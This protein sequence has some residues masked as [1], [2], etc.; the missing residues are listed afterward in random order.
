MFLAETFNMLLNCF[1]MERG[2]KGSVLILAILVLGIMVFLASYFI[3]FGL[4][5]SG[6]ARNQ[7]FASQTYYLAESGVAE[8]IFKLKNDPAWKNAFETLPTPS[9]PNCSLWSIS[10]FQRAGG[11][12]QNGGYNITVNNLGCAK[13]EIVSLAYLDTGG[14][15]KAQRVVKVKV[16]KA[17]GNPISDYGVFTGGASE[18]LDI[19]ATNP[20]H[21]H[22]GSLF[23]NNI[24]KVRDGSL[25][26]VDGKA[27][28]NGNILFSSGGQIQG[29]SCG[30][31][32]CQAGCATSTECPPA[33]ITS[34]PLDIISTNST[35]YRSQAQNDDCS[36][37]RNDGKTNCIFATDEFERMLWMYYPQFS[38]PTNVVVYVDGDVNIRAGQELTVNGVLA[39]GRDINL[40]SSLCWSR[41][42]Y[43][44]LRCGF[45]RVTVL[46]PGAPE[47]NLPSG[48]LAYRKINTSSW[49]GFGFS[50]LNVNGL[51]YS[52]DETKLSSIAA[53][54]VIHGGVIARKFTLSSLWNGTDIYLDSDVIVDT[55][56]NPQYSSIITIDHWEE[57]Y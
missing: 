57:E 4:T 36:S 29:V 30:S 25:V 47:D 13:A 19:S 34:P 52:G 45:A 1:K 20:M 21:V 17:M 18:N 55:L 43:P 24:L 54:I 35:S 11:I 14:S 42:E 49:L 3:S 41:G 5:G 7:K 46:R 16:L 37:V 32:L 6:M 51:I 2:R 8:A 56:G 50:A 15:K 31:N 26:Q 10:P 22:N 44:Y 9:N 23:S 53:P 40:G 28:A 12:F 27:L 38:L 33:A 39:A 48:L